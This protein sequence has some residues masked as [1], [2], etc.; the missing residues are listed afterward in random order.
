MYS[1]NKVKYVIYFYLLI[2][3]FQNHPEKNNNKTYVS[4]NFLHLLTKNLLFHIYFKLRNTN[5]HFKL[6][7]FLCLLMPS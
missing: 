5:N 6:L 4:I 2:E 7:S 1:Y 3:D